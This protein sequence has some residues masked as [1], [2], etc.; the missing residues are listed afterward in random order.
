MC[1]QFGKQINE[2][3][4]LRAAGHR[5]AQTLVGSAY[6]LLFPSL[7]RSSL[8][9]MGNRI[10]GAFIQVLHDV[11]RVHGGTLSESFPIIHW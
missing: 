4:H 6:L 9:V 2:T 3:I 11:G 7:S 10:H 5:A 8:P 1:N